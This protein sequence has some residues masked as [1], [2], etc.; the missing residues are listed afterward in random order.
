MRLDNLK[1]TCYSDHTYAERPKSFLWQG[2]EYEVKEIEKAW[3]EP[4]KKLFKITTEKGKLFEL[5]YTEA[6][7]EWSL[8]AEQSQKKKK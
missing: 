3:Q 5:C 4:G 7:D 2:I 8:R 1:V 6:I